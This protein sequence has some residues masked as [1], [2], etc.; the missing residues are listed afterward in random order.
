[1]MQSLTPGQECEREDCSDDAIPRRCRRKIDLL[2]L[3]PLP[4]RSKKSMRDRPRSQE[5][6]ESAFEEEPA[7]QAQSDPASLY[8][9]RS[10]RGE[11]STPGSPKCRIFYAPILDVIPK[12]QSNRCRPITSIPC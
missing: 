11:T 1:M 7:A 4:C 10:L 5:R 3:L 2:L 8:V 6:R 12:H 9:C